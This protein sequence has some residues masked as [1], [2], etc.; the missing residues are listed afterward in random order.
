MSRVML[1]DLNGEDT[2]HFPLFQL[3]DVFLENQ[4]PFGLDFGLLPDRV[5][6]KELIGGRECRVMMNV[7]VPF[8]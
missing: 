5:L 3:G 8:E 2:N 7:R 6:S 4:P 1:G